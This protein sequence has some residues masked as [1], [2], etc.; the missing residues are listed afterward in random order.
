LSKDIESEFY[1]EVDGNG[2][3]ILSLCP[4]IL[5]QAEE[6]TNNSLEPLYENSLIE[7]H[8]FCE[9]DFSTEFFIPD[10][11][12]S[13]ECNGLNHSFR[14][15]MNN[16]NEITTDCISLPLSQAKKENNLVTEPKA[17]KNN[18]KRKA[19]ED[20]S[21]SQDEANIQTSK[22]NQ[23]RNTSS[24]YICGGTEKCIKETL[25]ASLCKKNKKIIKISE[26]NNKEYVEDFLKNMISLRLA[27]NI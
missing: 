10:I 8:A 11:A 23:L 22:E 19:S 7:N 25:R 1:N 27:N 3:D 21:E 4:K 15:L 12:C 17:S 13:E 6:H 9:V 18:R 14:D 26:H 2:V 5:D 16:K 20:E 24:E